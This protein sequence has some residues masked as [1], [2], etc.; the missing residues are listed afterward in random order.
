MV[1][2]VASYHIRACFSTDGVCCGLARL[3][4]TIYSN[5]LFQHKFEQKLE[6]E[7]IHSYL[8][9][10]ICDKCLLGKNFNHG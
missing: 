2:S 7:Q 10:Q 3:F 9:W 4:V 1:L 5:L 6:F 8:Q